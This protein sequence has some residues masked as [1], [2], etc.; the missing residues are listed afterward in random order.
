MKKTFPIII[1]A[2]YFLIVSCKSEESEKSNESTAKRLFQE[3]TI[4]VKVAPVSTGDFNAEIIS[5]G[6]VFAINK[7]EVIF[8]FPEQIKAVLV[9]NGD[10]VHKGQLLAVLDP[11]EVVSRQSRSRENIAKSIVE[12]DDRLIDYGYRLKDSSTVPEPIMRMARI[13]SGYNNALYDYADAR[14]SVLKTRIV[15]PFT[16]KIADVEARAFNSSGSFK[17]LCTLIDDAWMKVEFSALETEYKAIAKGAAIEVIPFGGG[18]TLK[19][20]VTQINPLIYENGIIKV[21]GK[22]RNDAAHLLDGMSV[23]VV[24]KNAIPGKLYIPKTAVVQRQDREVVFTYEDGHA[25][26]N[27]VET[28]LQNTNYVTV[29]SGLEKDK[30]VIINNNINLA[31]DSEVKL[32]KSASGRD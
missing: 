30:L 13:K 25:R 10:F 9:K 7:S 22:V 17:K 3:E 11:S 2:V 29:N 12:L 14:K 28:G 19:G 27:Y 5:N 4:E 20:T 21:V 6:K 18:I 31:H 15:A 23:R 1:C 32:D 24:V 16:G 8:P 26:W